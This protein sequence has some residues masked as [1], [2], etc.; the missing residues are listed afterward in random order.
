MITGDF[1]NRYTVDRFEGGFA[2]CLNEEN[3]QREV[4]LLLLPEEVREGD[5][6]IL[7]YGMW[8]ID[9]DETAARRERIEKKLESLWED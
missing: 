9:E 1:A 5:V 3:V 7:E 4:P 6:L 2:V 8:R